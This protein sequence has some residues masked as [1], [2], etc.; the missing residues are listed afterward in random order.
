MLAA[1]LNSK[2]Y[3]KRIQA[4]IARMPSLSTTV[5]KVL[6]TC[7]DPKASPHDLNR[8]IS[9][10]PVLTGQVLRL[11]N[12]AYYALPNPITSLPRAIIMLGLNTVKNL[13]LSLAIL[14]TM[15]GRNFART[16]SVNDFWAH[17]L[18]VGV[19]AK[20]LSEIK[21]ANRS[22]CE[23]F[24]IAGLLHD[25]G[26]IPLSKQFPEQYLKTLKHSGPDLQPL[27]HA[28]NEIFGIDHCV[29]GEMIAQKWQLGKKLI[30][31]LAY[32]HHP[33]EAGPDDRSFVAIVA[34]ANSFANLWRIGS[35]GNA[36]EDGAMM[37]GFIAQ[38]EVDESVGDHLRERV[39]EKI[40][41]AKIFLEISRRG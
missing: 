28:E 8:V 12:S 4:Y 27:F 40:E 29:V 11:I 35:S 10:D 17:C 31:S 39:L 21:G 9:L 41:K 30:Q 24:F 26:K 22:T 15:G 38:A 32:H 18:C 2:A 25:L 14:D 16:I 36:F 19:T 3:L 33:D 1:P 37:A 13:A 6:E 20:C 7:N 23:D 5:T 34:L